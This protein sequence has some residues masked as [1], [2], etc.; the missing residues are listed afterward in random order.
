M[1]RITIRVVPNSSNDEVLEEVGFL[2][3][4]TRAKAIDGKANK[5]VIEILAKHFGV[6]KSRI[7]IV[8]GEKGREKVIQ[9]IS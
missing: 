3:V 9:V 1:K 8:R 5:A 7:E 4:R 6:R 2:K